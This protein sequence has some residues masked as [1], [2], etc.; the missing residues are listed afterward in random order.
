[1]KRTTDIKRRKFI[2]NSLAAS[3]YVGTLGMLPSGVLAGKRKAS[4]SDI[5]NVGLIGCRNHGFGMLELHIDQ[6]DARCIALCD[7]DQRV[8]DSRTNDVK[9]RQGTAPKQYGDYRKLLENKDIDAVV[10]GTPDHW[11]CLNLTAAIDAGKDVYVEKPMANSI[12]EI[13]IMT[14]TAK[15]SKQIVQVGQQ[16]RSGTHWKEIM[17]VIQ[18]GQIGYLRKIKV[19]GNFHYGVGIPVVPDGPEPNHV[20]YDFWLGPAPERTFNAS[21]F[22]SK[23]RM[24]W[25]YGG[26]LLTDWGVHLID[27]ALWAKKVD[28]MPLSV[29]AAGGNYSFKDFA[30]ETPDTLS[31]IYEMKDFVLTWDHT[32]G[33][34]TGPYDKHYG[35]AFRGDNGTII[36]NRE[37]WELKPEW[38][39]EEYATTKLDWTEGK[40]Y[41]AEHVRNFLDSIKT[42]EQPN[43][44]VDKGRL[45]AIYSHLGN[46][47]FRT[48]E[49]IVY[50]QEK[51]EI[52]TSRK[53]NELVTPVYRKP[54]K[55]P[56]A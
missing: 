49:K 20:N 21:R 2:Q 54:W 5:I 15:K 19:W 55:L 27:M 23:W 41:H 44:T 24:F 9:E 11:H 28:Y 31:V 16:Q 12:A 34:E 8:L 38:R 25:D 46:I 35:L 42:R 10:I 50:D 47:A 29:S 3:A 36:A 30:H 43:C 32:A 40:R 6:P 53:A 22:H 4:P 1:M 52:T 17:D 37:G 51:K 33:T 39:K 45:A 48:G 13:E 26:G 18:S 7:V 14:H 56:T